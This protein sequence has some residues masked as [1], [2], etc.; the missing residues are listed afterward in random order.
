MCKS[1]GGS[2]IIFCTQEACEYFWRMSMNQLEDVAF[3]RAP[4][5]SD[6]ISLLAT[7]D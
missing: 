4:L 6:F 1:D 5:S 2:L 3:T 7:D